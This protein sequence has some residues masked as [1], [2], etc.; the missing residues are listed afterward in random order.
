MKKIILVIA[1]VLVLGGFI[2]FQRFQNFEKGSSEDQST[3]PTQNSPQATPNATILYKD[4]AYTG[5]VGSASQYGDVQIKV[6]ITN[7]KITDIEFLQFPNTPGHTSEVNSAALP[8][9]KQEAITVQSANVD[10]VSGATQ[11]TQGFQQTL[12]SALDQAKV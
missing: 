4:G 10:I 11:T 12:Q 8:I 2:I 5:A 1:V 7:G 3:Q 9:L 6:T